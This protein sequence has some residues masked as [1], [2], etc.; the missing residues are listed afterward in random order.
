[1]YIFFL[2]RS[3]TFFPIFFQYVIDFIETKIPLFFKYF[4]DFIET[5]IPLFYF[6]L[7]YWNQ[8]SLIF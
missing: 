2:L 3:N 6:Y 7:F 5:K 8:D 1:M 4:I